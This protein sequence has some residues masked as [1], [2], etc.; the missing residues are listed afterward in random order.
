MREA[1]RQI[2]RAA[3]I[4]AAVACLSAACWS[5]LMPPFQVPDEPTHFAYTQQLA[6]NASMPTSNKSTY[7]QEERTVLSDVHQ[8]EV[9]QSPEHHPISTDAEQRHLNEDLA[10]HPSRHGE[11]GVGGSYSDPPLYYLLETVP[12]GLASTGTLL[13]QLELMR[14]LSALLAGVAALFTFLFIREALPGTPWAWTVGALAVALAPL[15]G[16]I[17][18]AVNPGSMLV[19][20]SAAILY[21][22]ARAFRRGLTPRLTIAIGAMI[23][24]GFLTSLNFIGLAPGIVLGLVVLA[25]RSSRSR[26]HGAY[27]SLGIALAIAATPV[28]LY[29]FY[30]LLSGHPVLGVVSSTLTFKSAHGS[31]LDKISYVWQLYLPRLPGM[32]DYFPG[33]STTRRLWFDRGVG[34]YGWLDTSFPTWVDNVALVAAAAMALL[35]ARALAAGR[36]ALRLRAAEAIVYC[37][38]A[39]GLLLLIGI[40]SNLYTSSEG[41]F[42]EPRYLLPL[43][44]LMGLGVALAARGAGRRWGPPTGAAIVVLFLAHDIFSQLLVVARYYG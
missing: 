39:L 20:I 14:L 17:G 12:Y 36:A 28:L 21:A 9:R 1:L 8:H 44:P 35:C 3:W 33:L 42:A 29:V 15:L 23:A 37:T 22:L 19:G 30:N 4:C 10:A 6:E 7:S 43:L 24:V 31:I 26:G 27:P 32:T 38:I 16:F 25:I 40:A 34:Y 13:D 5:I 18:G 41:V 2:P 11:G